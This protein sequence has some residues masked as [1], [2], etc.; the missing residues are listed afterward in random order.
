MGDC[1]GLDCDDSDPDIFLG[2]PELCD[3]KDNDCDRMDE[4][5]ECS[6]CVDVDGDGFGVAGNCPGFDCNDNN[7]VCPN[8]PEVCDNL[9]NDC[10]SKTDEGVVAPR[11]RTAKWRAYARVLSRIVA[12]VP[13]P[14]IPDS[15]QEDTELTCDNLDND[16]DGQLDEDFMFASDPNNCGGCDIVCM[17]PAPSCQNFNVRGVLSGRLARHRYGR[18]MDANIAAFQR[19]VASM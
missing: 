16:C 9:D 2:A 17:V 4:V 10:D 6:P 15:Y 5:P 13:G 7:S 3:G 1:L 8:A 14:A 19:T 18:A 12:M 11:E